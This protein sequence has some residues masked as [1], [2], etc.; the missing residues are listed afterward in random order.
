[1]PFIICQ[2]RLAMWSAHENPILGPFRGIALDVAAD[3]KKILLIADHMLVTGTLPKPHTAFA[4][5][6]ALKR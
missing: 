6:K 4:V 2:N 5:C 3:F 1:M